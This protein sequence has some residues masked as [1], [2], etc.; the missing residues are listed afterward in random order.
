MMKK[1][2]NNILGKWRITNMSGW[3]ADYYDMDVP[4]YIEISKGGGGHFQ[5]GLVRGEIYGKVIKYP[6]GN[7]FRF[8]WEGYDENDPLSG[9]GWIKT[10]DNSKA[11]G[12]FHIHRGD[13]S[14]FQAKRIK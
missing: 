5:F 2:S 12:E 13:D 1:L 3:D 10:E 7:R 8:T 4:A 6:D 14:D 11:I 9:S